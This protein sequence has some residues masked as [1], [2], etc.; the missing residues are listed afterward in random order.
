MLSAWPC[1]GGTLSPNPE[2]ARATPR[3]L[4]RAHRHERHHVDD[5]EAV[6]PNSRDFPGI[7]R[8]EPQLVEPEL[9]QD[10]RAQAELAERALLRDLVPRARRLRGPG[11]VVPHP[12]RVELPLQVALRRKVHDDA[13]ALLLD[14]VD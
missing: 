11:R 12:E 3:L 1:A 9:P 2:Y 6:A 10:L 13:V 14:D 7:V 5:F 4:R 8:E